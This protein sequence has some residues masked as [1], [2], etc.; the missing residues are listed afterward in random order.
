MKHLFI[1]KTRNTII[2]VLTILLSTLGVSSSYAY[3]FRAGD[4]FYI[5]TYSR[6]DGDTEFDWGEADAH[7]VMWIWKDGGDGEWLEFKTKEYEYNSHK[8]RILSQQ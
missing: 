1:M 4:K 6:S 7:L 2:T 5:N 8:V 3:Y